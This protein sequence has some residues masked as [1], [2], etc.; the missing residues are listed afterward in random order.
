MIANLSIL[1]RLKIG[2]MCFGIMMGVVFPF[3]ASFFVVFKPGMALWFN[4]GCVVAGVVVGSFSYFLVQWLLLG[5]LQ[6]I[7]VRLKDIAEG[8][9]DLTG[10]ITINSRDMIGDL[11]QYFNNF[12][13]LL[14]GTISG[15]QVRVDSVSTLSE[16]LNGIAQDVSHGVQAQDSSSQRLSLSLQEISASIGRN[17]ESAKQTEEISTAVSAEATASREAVGEAIGILRAVTEKISI[18]VEIARQTNLL[19][20]NAAIEAS[21]AG[22]AGRGFS[23]VAAEVRQLAE[24]SQSAAAE[25]VTISSQGAAI[26]QKTS[27]MLDN[28]VNKI[29]QT[30]ELVHEMGG[31]TREQEQTIAEL[32]GAVGQV[33]QVAQRNGVAVENMAAASADFDRQVV[34][35]RKILAF[36]KTDAQWRQPAEKEVG[37]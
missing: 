33:N 21:R 7:V 32:N 13:S 3:Y 15:I 22:E 26:S 6:A 2:M 36:F 5:H 35:L 12:I 30:T 18:I 34:E 10:R 16:R 1:G 24:R 17:S 11:G 4:L 19:A 8:E 23:V 28:L 27:L 29:L 37:W 14:Q 25:I 20:L 31:W 9:G